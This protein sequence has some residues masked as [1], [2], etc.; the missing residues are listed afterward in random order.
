MNFQ[1]MSEMQWETTDQILVAIHGLFVCL[2][3]YYLK[4]YEW[5]SMK[6]SRLI[7]DGT[8]NMPLNFGRD[9][10]LCVCLCLFV[11]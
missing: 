3:V 11:F 10:W 7:E 2:L 1:E 8:G 9:M 4:T 6:F 5:I